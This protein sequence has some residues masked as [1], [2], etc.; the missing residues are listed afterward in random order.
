MK[1]RSEIDEKFK[2]DLSKFCRDDDDFLSRLKKVERRID[3]FAKYDGKLAD[4]KLLFECL[5]LEIEIGKEFSLIAEYAHLKL[6]EDNADRVANELCE[7]VNFVA[8]KLSTSTSFIDVQISKF[9]DEKL[10]NLQKNGKFKDYRRFFEAILRNKK[11]TLSQKE[12]LLLAKVGE[13]V[14]GYSENFDKFTDADM[15]FQPIL[16]SKGK[17]HEINQSNYVVLFR[18][19]DRKL[20]ENAYRELNGRH[21]AYI[22]F[23]ASNYIS[24]VKEDC[25]FAKLRHHS[26][27]LSASIFEEEASEQVYQNLVKNVRANVAILQKYYELKRKMLKLDKFAVYDSFAPIFPKQTRKYTFAQAIELIKKATA[28]MGEE[29]SKLIDRAVSERWIDVYPNQN[30]QSGAFSSS[31]YGVT[32][33]VLTNF[34]NDLESVFTLAHE[35]GHAMHSYFSEKCQ[36]YQTTDYVI[37]VAEV[38]STVNEMLL[39]NYLLSGAKTKQERISFF[40]KF[41]SNV[42]ATIFRQTMFAEFEEFSHGEYENQ[43]PLSAELL[44]NKYEELNNF[45]YGKKVKQIKEMRFEWARI[46]HFFTAFY[47]YKYATGLISAINISQKLLNEKGFEKK[48]IKFLSSGCRE[49]PISLLKIADCDLTDQKTFDAAFELC[50][51]FICKWQNELGQKERK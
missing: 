49:D 13:F 47:V 43:Q 3:D 5:Q 26:S 32:P 14:G 19:A 44:C 30:K 31:V 40:D 8:T 23:L 48:Y 17:K 28:C 50:E 4:E 34:E 24:S 27:A 16:D 7:R 25:V 9:S 6:C 20:R 41:L 22:N 21:G 2:W 11:H 15:K 1:K 46:P 12:E 29:Y 39:L 42:R 51:E 37:F 35:L 38:A 45:Y 10:K 33:V 36:P 18:S